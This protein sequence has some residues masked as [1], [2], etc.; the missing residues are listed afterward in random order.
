M[1]ALYS[2]M[3]IYQGQWFLFPQA[4][5][6]RPD[7]TLQGGVLKATLTPSRTALAQIDTEYEADFVKLDQMKAA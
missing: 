2:H 3:G 4:K 6:S 1:T 7:C 5:N